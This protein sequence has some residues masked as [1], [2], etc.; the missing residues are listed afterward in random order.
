MALWDTRLRLVQGLCGNGRQRVRRI[1]EQ[2][3][4]CTRRVHRRTQA[5]ERRPQPPASWWWATA[6]GRPRGRRLVVATL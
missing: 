5:M 1:A 4:V 6:E 2:T 3:G